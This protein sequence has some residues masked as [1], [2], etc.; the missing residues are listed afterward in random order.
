MYD[1]LQRSRRLDAVQSGC[2][3]LFIVKQGTPWSSPTSATLGLFWASHS[4]T[5]PSCRPARHPPKAQPATGVTHLV[6]QRPGV[7]PC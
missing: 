6:V 3:T 7:L 2:S 4:T 1:K 5:T